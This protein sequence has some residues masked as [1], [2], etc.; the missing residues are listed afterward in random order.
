M[1]VNN[2]IASLDRIGDYFPNLKNLFLM[3]NRIAQK[4][5]LDNIATCRQLTN[6]NLTGNPLSEEVGY[7]KSVIV[8]IRWLSILDFKKVTQ[9]EKKEAALVLQNWVIVIGFMFSPFIVLLYFLRRLF[10]GYFF[11]I[12]SFLFEV[13]SDLKEELVNRLIDQMM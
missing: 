5:Q 12:L 6:L 8:V 13:L 1:L 2:R 9:N 10:W 4:A 7:R 3:G 11:K